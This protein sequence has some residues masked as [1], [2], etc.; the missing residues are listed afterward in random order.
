M[1]HEFTNVEVKAGL[2]KAVMEQIGIF[3]PPKVSLN[4]SITYEM[5]NSL[6]TEG[7]KK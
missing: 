1:C 3:S 2:K 6:G 7:E 5:R 4:N